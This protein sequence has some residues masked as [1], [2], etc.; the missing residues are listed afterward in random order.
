MCMYLILIFKVKY[1]SQIFLIMGPTSTHISACGT[2]YYIVSRK[3]NE[4][5]NCDVQEYVID[6][7]VLAPAINLIQTT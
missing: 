1:L 7:D 5:R 4:K 2:Q 3:D 6:D